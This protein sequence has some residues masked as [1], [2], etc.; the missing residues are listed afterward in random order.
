ML[1]CVFICVCVLVLLI[2][3][4]SLGHV[5]FLFTAA[6]FFSL[7]GWALKLTGPFEKMWGLQY[8]SY[9]RMNKVQ[10]LG[11]WVAAVF[12]GPFLGKP[13]ALQGDHI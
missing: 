11:V 6:C 10:G 3:V 5:I 8:I 2:C 12:R 9:I 4:A 7:R 1:P 13:R